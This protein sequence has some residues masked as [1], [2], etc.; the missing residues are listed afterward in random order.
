MTN[1]VPPTA[2]VSVKGRITF[3]MILCLG[4][5][6]AL[7]ARAAWIQ[8]GSDPRLEQMSRRQFQ[9]KVLIRPRRGAILDQT[10]EAL[11]INTE[12]NS[13]A[14]NPSKI[15]N[16]KTL[17][18]LL[19]KA[20]DVPYSRILLKLQ[21]KKEFVWIKRHIPDSEMSR[22]T[23][24]KIMEAD[25][26]LVPGLWLVKESKR[27]YPHRELAAQ[28]LGDTNLD[29]EGLEGVELKA[30]EKLRGKVVSFNAIKDALGRPT[31]IDAVAANHVQD[32]E[33]VSLTIDA[34]LQF[35][36]EEELRNAVKKSNAKSGS[37]LVMN[38]VNG[39]ILAMASEPTFNPNEKG[40]NPDHRRSRV[41]TDG[42]EPGSIM[43]AVLVASALSNGW[44]LSDQVWGERGQ[45]FV[46]GKRISEAEVHEKFEWLSLK[47]L[48]KVSSNVGAAKVALKLGADKYLS[49][50]QALGFGTR[51]NLGFP[52]EIQG[53]IP[54]RKWQPLTLANVGFGQG[55]LVTRLQM[56]RAYASFINGGWLVQPTIFKTPI[57][58]VKVEV[59][60]RVFTQ[61][62]ADQV[63]EAL[64][65][66]TEEKGTG[67]KAALPGY[68]VAGKT[69]T[70]Q[71][72][73]PNTGKYSRSKHIAS[74]VG[75]PVGV[76]PKVVILTTIDEPHG[77]YYASETAAPL[78]REVLNAVASRYSMPSNS[79]ETAPKPVV[80]SFSK[81][82]ARTV[83]SSSAGLTTLERL[84]T[85]QAKAIAAAAPAPSA[86][87]LEWNG[88][89][90]EGGYLWTMPS[91]TG[92]SVR[93]AIR[94]L[95]GHPFHME[96]HGVGIVQSQYPPEGKSVADGETIKLTLAE[97]Q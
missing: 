30:D 85:S 80:A 29:Q 87:A 8:M 68:R 67:V 9:S 15:A 5:A 56:A 84:H 51:T 62:V 37:V 55:I 36:V 45:L 27:V 77:V 39:E 59:P 34:S 31:F 7:T 75:F 2:L 20:T 41:V 65:G 22:L 79:P 60:K 74:F 52:G 78:F 73:E 93:E 10:G 63:V 23:K 33:P 13:L 21:E 44:K 38:A 48:I 92:L 16:K 61:K 76:E 49:T 35:S 26:D 3:M 47:K 97:P 57:D 14:A 88:N 72:V 43:K 6:G 46:Q 4:I 70:A 58:G 95:E 71:M 54:P 18:R 66:V 82:S 25:G 17:A 32:G 50:L 69:G 64:L 12:I 19:A 83:A 94:T 89:S 53:R 86:G 11:A 24:W 81:E 91:L 28:I 1:T 96:V 90:A 40:A 42:F